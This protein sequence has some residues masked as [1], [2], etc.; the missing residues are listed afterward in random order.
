[1]DLQDFNF[2]VQTQGVT[3]LAGFNSEKR[4]EEYRE[5]IMTNGY[6]MTLEIVDQSHSVHDRK[7]K[8][9]AI[10]NITDAFTRLSR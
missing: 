6:N 7:E 8:D 9:V 10:R 2:V 1:M 5:F 3:P 4:A